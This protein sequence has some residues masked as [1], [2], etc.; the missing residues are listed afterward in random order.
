MHITAS[1]F[2]SIAPEAASAQAHSLFLLPERA[3]S[4]GGITIL[5][6][7]DGNTRGASGGGYAAG[8]RKVV[9]IAEHLARR[10]DVAVMVACILSPDNVARRSDRFFQQ[11]YKEFVQLGVAI[12]ARGALVAAGVRMD[13]CGDLGPLRA[14]G[15]HG[16]LLADAIE[17]VAAL[18][19]VVERPALLLRLGVGYG[20]D[21]AREV[22]ADIVL[23]TGMEEPGALRL[24]GL[25]TGERI[26]CF[27]TTTLWPDIEPRDLDEV[28]ALGKQR[29]GARFARGY[30]AEAIAE[31][32]QALAEADIDAPLRMT[33]PASAPH[34][35]VAAAL[36][37][38]AVL[39]EHAKVGVELMMGSRD[40][41]RWLGPSAGARQVIRVV[42]GPPYEGL[43]GEGDIASVLAPGQEPP[44]FT[45]PDWPFLEHANAHACAPTA[46][47][48]VAGIRA[49]LR[50]SAA[51][52]P[53]HGADRVIAPAPERIDAIADRFAAKILDWAAGAGLRIPSAPWQRAAENYAL[54]G[55]FIHFRVPTAWDPAGAQWESRAELAAKYMVLVAAGDEAV[56]DHVAEGETSEERWRRIEAASRYLQGALRG[57][58]SAA[59]EVGGA[60]VMR[61]IAEQWRALFDHHARSCHPGVAEGFR[62]G[63]EDLY[64]RSVDELRAGSTVDPFAHGRDEQALAALIEDRFAAAPPII[65]ALARK[66]VAHIADPAAADALRVL[67][68]LR[69]AGSAIGAGLLFRAAALAVPATYV[70]D[71]GLVLL[72]ATAMLL[73]Y[74]VRLANDLSGFLDTPGGDR[75]PK[76]NACT[77][78]LSPALSGPARAARIVEVVV[79]C[80]RLAAWIGAEV[81][82]HIESLAAA[83]PA[84]GEAVRRGAFVGRRVYEVGHYTT[85][86]RAEMLAI[87]AELPPPREIG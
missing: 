62:V 63:L 81:G 13:V 37:R 9:T 12:R 38:L 79:T 80:Q 66:L 25:R 14:R 18:T 78:L 30:G 47:G 82:D 41:W 17:A 33:I 52:P 51:H 20:R 70:T 19:A 40:D 8:G 57:G 69:E 16:A 39:H 61:A 36:D 27:A 2:E 59:P 87:F 48:I 83:W 10:P 65:A 76:Q 84:M 28:I 29:A 56:F 75:D 49:A 85:A 71:R 74:S 24:S 43:P 46:A 60:A 23:R 68:Y 21:T 58:E 72:D 86:S 22:S 45:L 7:A 64:A 31:I 73:D 5:I 32:V 11:V 1:F 26:A 50:F 42:S 55:L 67:L 6:L 53:L 3:P 54:T 4:P 15:G 77:I 34:A 35:E 44:S